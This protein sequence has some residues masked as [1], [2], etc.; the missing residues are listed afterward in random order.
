[1]ILFSAKRSG[2]LTKANQF[3]DVLGEEFGDFDFIYYNKTGTTKQ[4]AL[5]YSFPK[6]S[7]FHKFI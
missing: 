3:S 7:S 1:M 6:L 5:R 2:F 4:N